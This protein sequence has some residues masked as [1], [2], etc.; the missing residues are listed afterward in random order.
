M[1]HPAAACCMGSCSAPVVAPC[2]C[3]KSGES[4]DLRG[5]DCAAQL[6][7]VLAHWLLLLVCCWCDAMAG[8]VGNDIEIFRSPNTGASTLVDAQ[9]N[10]AS[11]VGK[12]TEYGKMVF[13]DVSNVLLSGESGDVAVHHAQPEG[14]APDRGHGAEG[15]TAGAGAVQS[16]EPW[17]P[18][19]LLSGTHMH[20]HSCPPTCCIG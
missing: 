6:L 7:A 15:S 19:L 16:A 18:W 4:C 11:V 1:V 9:G 5:L 3:L 12:P 10:R 2:A 20:T 17:Q 13:W 14:V 8:D